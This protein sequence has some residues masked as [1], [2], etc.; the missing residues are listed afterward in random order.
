MRIEEI[1]Y[2]HSE[3]S[4]F[5]NSPKMNYGFQFMR[6]IT[7]VTKSDLKCYLEENNRGN[8]LYPN[9][10]FKMNVIRR[11]LIEYIFQLIQQHK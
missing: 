3:I 2:L 1:S 11:H 6:L 7:L 8:K 5:T 9:I 10:H 4:I